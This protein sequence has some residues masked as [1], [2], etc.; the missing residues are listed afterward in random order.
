[1]RESQRRM[2]GTPQKKNGHFCDLRDLALIFIKNLSV[3][4]RVRGRRSKP[5]L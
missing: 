2:E 5:G 3:T 4:E 1:M